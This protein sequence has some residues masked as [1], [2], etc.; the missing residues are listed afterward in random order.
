MSVFSSFYC[1][2]S[3]LVAKVGGGGGCVAEE[4]A[5]PTMVTRWVADIKYSG[6]RM[7]TTCISAS[8]GT[9]HGMHA[10]GISGSARRRGGAAGGPR[11]IGT[12]RGPQELDTSSAARLPRIVVVS[13]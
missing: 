11:D 12:E 13:R 8:R 10:S 2:N 7:Y 1:V 9:C 3:C 6:T 5:P 4:C